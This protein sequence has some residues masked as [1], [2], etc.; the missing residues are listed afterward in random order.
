[1]LFPCT[2]V[3]LNVKTETERLTFDLDVFKFEIQIGLDEC[4][5]VYDLSS[6]DEIKLGLKAT[7][8]RDRANIFDICLVYQGRCLTFII[9]YFSLQ[10]TFHIYLNGICG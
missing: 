6:Y 9:F 7:W 2:S 10:L 8:K 4:M 3:D 1:M 5:I